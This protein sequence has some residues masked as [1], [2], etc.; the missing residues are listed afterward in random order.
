MLGSTWWPRSGSLTERL[1]ERLTAEVSGL[2]VTSTAAGTLY[3]E[4]NG[5]PASVLSYRYPLLAEPERNVELAVR[6]ASL[7]A[8]FAIGAAACVWML[9]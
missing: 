5:V 7:G 2:R 8:G 1:A 3:L 9:S 6:V 4:V